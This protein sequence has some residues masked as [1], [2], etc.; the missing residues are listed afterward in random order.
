[1]TIESLTPEQ[2]ALVQVWYADWLAAGRATGESDRTRAKAAI[3]KMYARLGQREPVYVFL[4]S[5]AA[6]CVAIGI[7]RAI[8]SKPLRAQLWDQLRDQLRAQL[9]AQLGAQLRAQLGD[10]LGDQLWDQLGAQLEDQL[11][12]QL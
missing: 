2:T 12:A 10:Q 3:S 6:C 7:L 1:M 9:G 8:A 4:D 11:W 5:P